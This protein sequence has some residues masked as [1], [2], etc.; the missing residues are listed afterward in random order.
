MELV[1]IKTWANGMR[2]GDLTRGVPCPRDIDLFVGVGTVNRE[3]QAAVC[4]ERVRNSWK[5]MLAVSALV[6]AAVAAIVY[7]SSV[8]ASLSRGGYSAQDESP[9]PGKAATAIEQYYG[10]GIA[11]DYPLTAIS[12]VI[13][14][15]DI[16]GGIEQGSVDRVLSA[17]AEAQ[18]AFARECQSNISNGMSCN[19]AGLISYRHN[20]NGEPAASIYSTQ[21][22]QLSYFTERYLSIPGK[23]ENYKANGFYTTQKASDSQPGFADVVFASALDD[24]AAS[25][26][27]RDFEKS[28]ANGESPNSIPGAVQVGSAGEL[29]QHRAA[30]TCKPLPVAVYHINGSSLEYLVSVLSQNASGVSTSL[31]GLVD[32]NG[33]RMVRQISCKNCTGS[34]SNAT[35]SVGLSSVPESAEEIANAFEK[36]G[37]KV[38]E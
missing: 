26:T 33:H 36:S 19:F 28:W 1:K 14:G 5:P 11:G 20:I 2:K 18:A 16:R 10:K 8:S 32:T 13:P 27:I 30:N 25:K 24:E 15:W 9:W 37:L 35:A 12:T 22:K 17:P 31:Y 29:S 6:A 38:E 7:G 34:I 3:R 21:Q 4:A 23:C